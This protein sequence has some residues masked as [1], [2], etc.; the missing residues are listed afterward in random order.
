MAK[1]FDQ[2]VVWITGGGTGIGRAMAEQLA[3]EGALVVVSGRRQDRLDE[4]VAA[5]E[6]AGGRAEARACDVTDEDAV[7]SVAD[8]IAAEHGGL[9]MVVANAGYSTGGRL[10]KLRVADFRRQLDVNVIGLFA[11]V[12]HALPHILER[13]GRV[14][15]M[16]SVS[17]ILTAPGTGAYSAS[18]AAVHALGMC[19]SI[20][21][22]DTGA[23]C[24]VVHPGFVVSEI[25]KVDNDG[26][27]QEDK[28]DLRPER[29]MWSAED[30]ARDMI[31]GAYKRQAEVIV[32]GH[33]KFAN[34]MGRHLPGVTRALIPRF[35][36]K[37]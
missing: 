5:I 22:A 12:H 14:V 25:G 3:Q 33:G 11:T 17:Y 19:L 28:P 30:A 24:T 29:L 1:R 7:K 21:L 20:E 10:H 26:V 6:A 9:D 13:D 23:S 8:G 34:A 31:T 16:G 27:Y 35:W 4:V 18:K 2:Q 32:T 37:P 15:L 36:S